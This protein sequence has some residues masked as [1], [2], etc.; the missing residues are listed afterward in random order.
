ML[1]V[2][3]PVLFLLYQYR[4]SADGFGSRSEDCADVDFED[5]Y[6]TT[7]IESCR[8]PDGRWADIKV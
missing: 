8:I 5:V 4:W 2:V 3:P 7:L 6:N 1:I